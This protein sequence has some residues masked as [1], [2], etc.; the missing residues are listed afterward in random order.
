MKPGKLKSIG[1]IAAVGLVLA[2]GAGVWLSQDAE[3]LLSIAVARERG[4]GSLEQK[5]MRLDDHEIVYLDG[6]APGGAPVL[7]L[8]GFAADKDNWT[9]FSATLAGAGYRVLAPDLPG[10]GESSRLPEH[11]YDI[12]NQVD[13]V[14]RFVQANGL[15]E[16]HIAGNS[17]G[18]HIAGAYAALHPAR[19]ISLGL[20][21]AG[22]VT[23]PEP[24]ERTLIMRETG[25]NPL[26][27]ESVEDFDRF[28]AFVFVEPPMLPT[29]VKQYF[30]DRAVQ[31]RAFND[32]IY[33]DI[34][35]GGRLLPLEPLLPRI[36]A[37]ALI[38]WGDS[39]RLLHPSGAQVFAAGLA[40]SETVILEACGH[41][42][43]IERPAETASIY[44]QFL[45]RSEDDRE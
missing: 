43:M 39:D 23:A 16:V 19:V 22:G 15:D 40:D 13:F 33:G 38:L 20:F 41:S 6:G 26:L 31:N 44:V 2:V 3:A 5:T 27:V 7:L 29:V 21:N 42:P 17:M 34:T 32:K 35:G 10:H 4:A 14:E 12:P 11:T 30:A 45:D 1:L 37:P 25:T 36:T 24:S 18:G 28:L 8:H 9:R